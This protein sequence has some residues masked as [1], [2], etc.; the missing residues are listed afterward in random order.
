M[1]RKKQSREQA[2]NVT[3]NT[4]SDWD[5]GVGPPGIISSF[6]FPTK[7]AK[8]GFSSLWFSDLKLTVRWKREKGRDNNVAPGQIHSPRA[9]RFISSTKV[10]YTLFGS[11]LFALWCRQQRSH[12]QKEFSK[13]HK[14]LFSY[15]DC[16]FSINRPMAYN[17]TI[18]VR[19]WLL[20]LLLLLILTGSEMGEMQA[21]PV[22]VQ[23]PTPLRKPY[24]YMNTGQVKKNETTLHIQYKVNFYDR[25]TWKASFD[26]KTLKVLFALGARLLLS[27]PSVM[28]AS[29]AEWRV[30]S[31]RRIVCWS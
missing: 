26:I 20:L 25:R 15:A 13:C 23:G 9:Q 19:Y 1:R 5:V 11:D 31:R 3:E 24:K 17:F 12:W 6:R 27:R 10:V 22:T 29:V 7:Q 4:I 18:I 16:T 2:T 30:T 28:G 14:R 8:A 21:G